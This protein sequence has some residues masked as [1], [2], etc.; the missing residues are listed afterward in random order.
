MGA[1]AARN[2]A[3]RNDGTL[4]LPLSTTA[5]LGADGASV[6]V[7]LS[8][9]VGDGRTD[10]SARLNTFRDSRFQSVR[11]TVHYVPDGGPPRTFSVSGGPVVVSFDPGA[12][13]T[14]RL[15]VIKGLGGVLTIGD[16]L[17]FLVC[18]LLPMRRLRDAALVVATMIGSQTVGLTVSAAFAEAMPALRAAAAMIAASALAVAAIQNIARARLAVVVV[19]TVI[20]GLLNGFAFGGAFALARQFAGSHQ[21][22]ALATF[23]AAVVVGECWIA[24]VFATARSRLSS[25][26]ATD[27]VLVP[28][29]S[30]VVAHTAL[31]HVFDRGTE[32]A[33]LGSVSVEHT[34]TWLALGWALGMLLVAAVEWLRERQTTNRRAALAGLD[35]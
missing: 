1:D 18:A 27:R 16:H 23:V 21:A 28:A 7:D 30:V 9:Q 13:E 12:L 19:V 6:D 26:G 15:F 25:F 11:T 2:L 3:V 14:I 4:L 24:A 20:F 32:L 17:L 33:Q 10:I 34:L 8:Y 5:R 29:L 22:V 35:A 31:H